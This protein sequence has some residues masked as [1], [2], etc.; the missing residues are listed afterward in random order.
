MNHVTEINSFEY[1]FG[2]LNFYFFQTG[3]A[4]TL[5]DLAHNDYVGYGV[6]SVLGFTSGLGY[7]VPVPFVAEFSIIGGLGALFLGSLAYIFFANS[8]LKI[9]EFLKNNTIKLSVYMLIASAAF[10]KFYEYS[11][12]YVI[13]NTLQFIVI[14]FILYFINICFNYIMNNK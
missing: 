10:F 6:S 3:S 9:L 5:S 2:T 13:K 11:V 7:T 12:L 8:V 14:G 1:L 4:E